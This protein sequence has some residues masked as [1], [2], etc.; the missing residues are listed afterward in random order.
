MVIKLFKRYSLLN[1]P[2]RIV[3]TGPKSIGGTNEI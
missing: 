3:K 2:T 1:K